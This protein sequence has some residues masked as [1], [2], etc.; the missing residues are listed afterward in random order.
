MK[1]KANEVEEWRDIPGYEGYYQASSLGRV[2]SLD[3]M[4]VFSDGR[5]RFYKG[6]VYKGNVSDR[7]RQIGLSKKG[8]ARIYR[9]SQVVA[10]AFLGHKPNGNTL[11]VDHINGD[12]LDDRLENLR[13]VTM[14]ENSSICYRGGSDSFSSKY[15][16]VSWYERGS[17]WVANIVYKG[18]T[19]HLGYFMNEVDAYTAYQLALSKIKDGSFSPDDY[20]PKWTSKYKGVSFDK[21]K[22][23]WAAHI[24]TGGEQTYLGCFHDEEE[25]FI[26]CQTALLEID[27]GSFNLHNYRVRWSSKYKGV[28][29]NKE[30]NKW[31]AQI[32]ANGK[33]IYI[34]LFHTE[35]EAHEAY[36]DKLNELNNTKKETHGTEAIH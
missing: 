10:M 28:S 19:S 13:I 3:R 36:Q 34:G 35:L 12:R 23:K 29:F 14:R 20:K 18:E 31:R 9:I 16:G 15:I 6:R 26:S 33:Q 7:Y 2:R 25:A 17:K 8:H 1:E 11:V 24:T 21:Q 4:T 22:G 32:S 30:G 27:R 5:K